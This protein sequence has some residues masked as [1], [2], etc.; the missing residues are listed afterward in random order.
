[1]HIRTSAELGERRAGRHRGVEGAAISARTG[2]GD[3]MSLCGVVLASESLTR[4]L[5][6]R[7]NQVDRATRFSA[8]V[9]GYFPGPAATPQTREGE[10]V[11]ATSANPVL[12]RQT[13]T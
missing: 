10:P 6:R 13:T 5:N 2:S 4:R 12:R 9:S 1:M 11:M 8:A 7:S 3:G